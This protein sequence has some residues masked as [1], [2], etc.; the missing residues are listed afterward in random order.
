MHFRLNY[1]SKS[2]AFN[3]NKSFL[4]FCIGAAHSVHIINL[5]KT[6]QTVHSHI[7]YFICQNYGINKSFVWYNFHMICRC[8]FKGFSVCLS[9]PHTLSHIR[10]YSHAH[11]NLHN[12]LENWKTKWKREK[13]VLLFH[14]NTNWAIIFA[15]RQI[16]CA[17]F[18]HNFCFFLQPLLMA[19]CVHS[20]RMQNIMG[21]GAL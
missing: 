17:S 20:M 12:A 9:E 4:I 6:I 16:F 19:C 14:A 1:T 2:N 3:F 10:K 7:H 15:F 11:C 18:F 8:I 21:I 13:S 5:S